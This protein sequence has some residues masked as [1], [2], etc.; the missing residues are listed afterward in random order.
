MSSLF[1]LSVTFK[2]AIFWL[3]LN[4]IGNLTSGTKV[5]EGKEFNGKK[6]VRIFSSKGCLI[7][8]KIL[9]LQSDFEEVL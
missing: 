9:I 6:G 3:S 2:I 8:N 1:F 4:T 7:H 5:S